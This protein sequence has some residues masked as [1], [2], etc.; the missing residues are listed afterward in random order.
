MQTTPAALAAEGVAKLTSFPAKAHAAGIGLDHAGD[1]LDQRRLAG[2]VL[3]QHG[4][5]LAALAGEVDALQGAHTA[6]AL[7]DAGQCEEGTLRLDR[8]LHGAGS[9]SDGLANARP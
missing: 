1:D 2:A 7:G 8:I 9:G 3:A 4:V 6:I 5:D